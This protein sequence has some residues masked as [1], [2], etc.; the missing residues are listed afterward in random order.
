MHIAIEGSVAGLAPG[1]ETRLFARG[2]GHDPG[3]E[4]AVAAI[5]ADV[6]AR[7]DDALRE[8][9]RRVDGV[10]LDALEVPRAT[11][12]AALASL[13][14]S[15]RAALEQAT[16]AISTF[17]RA[18][19]PSP[20]EMEVRPG[21]RLG[22]RAEPLRRVGVYAPGGRAAYPS[23][24]L[25]GVVPARIAGVDE[26]IVCSPPGPDGF[27]RPSV[28]AAC[29]L[30][31]AD[32][33]F[34]LGGAGAIAALAFGTGS[35]PRAD[36][37]FGPGNAY[38]NEA[39]RQLTGAVAIDTPAGPS[40]VL[41]IA[42]DAANPELAAA[43][44][45]AQSEHD[46]D[47]AAVLVAT[48]GATV[49]AVRTSLRRLMAEQ[50]RHDIIA[51]ALAANGGLL[52]AADLDEALDFAARYAPEH[53][54]LLVREP[55]RALARVRSAGTVLLGP[56]S[57]VPFGDYLTGANHVLPTGGLAR[58][59]SGLSTLDFLRWFTYQEIDDDAATAL[60]G[61][62]RTLAVAEGLPAHAAAAE[63]RCEATRMAQAEGMAQAVG[64]AATT[65]PVRGPGVP[66][67]TNL[68]RQVWGHEPAN[69]TPAS[70]DEE[71]TAA[72]GRP[73][74]PA[75]KSRSGVER[76]AQAGRDAAP[77]A[78][79]EAE[80]RAR[81]A[82]P[83]R[84]AYRALDLYNPRR[85]PV[86]VDLS[87]NTSLFGPSPAAVRALSKFGTDA[88]TRYPSTYADHLKT[89]LADTL[90]VE[91]DNIATG[92][93]SDDVIDSAVRAFCDPG[94]VIAY[95]EPTFEMVPTLAGMNAAR[96]AA[97]S[98]GAGFA[99]DADALLAVRARVTYV[100]RPN[101]P[102][103][104]LFERAAVERVAAGAAGVVLVDEAYAD[105]AG[106]TLLDL[107]LDGHPV[108]IVRT[109]SKAYGL[110]GLRVGFAV[111]P[112][113]LIREIE[114]ARGP[115]KVNTTA[116]AAAAAAL[117]EDT[118]WVQVNVASVRQN[119]T[120]LAGALEG[121]GLQTW[122]S[123]A[124]FL[125]VQAPEQRVGAARDFAAA[126]RAHG[127]AVRPFPQLP[128]AG[129]CI[130]VS[131]GPWSMMERLLEAVGEE[132]STATRTHSPIRPGPSP[133]P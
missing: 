32:R 87:D 97:V 68:D 112:A 95:P 53:L 94:D 16:D 20:L 75:A 30:A 15:V 28:L 38:V 100:C 82:V 80:R 92:C 60:A 83:L 65:G 88:V 132:V 51:A 2:R 102:T 26:V 14:A 84:S 59:H 108:V 121:V 99:L 12:D 89:A 41:V 106:E 73:S 74:R 79:A 58:A 43:E 130:R 37:I 78:P 22:R 48:N 13:D 93:G 29:T 40:E 56:S 55:R 52:E 10:E 70:S 57:S 62:T 23:S 125:L 77:S 3:V 81:I 7:G 133:P 110:A 46:P 1:D 113:A 66:R 98:L 42:D 54:V 119:R 115:Y 91:P 117:R 129:E 63:L 118:A 31:R 127:I 123:A 114:K 128:Q 76:S 25:M 11:L 35:V 64:R 69:H 6:R 19:L 61:P 36:K 39:K 85:T 67:R 17:H 45:I 49:R 9:A 4:R 116:E 126:L 8:L 27:P 103:G 71:T 50:P 33:V 101:N 107:A 86:A 124:N 21:V 90:G 120:R 72:A 104:T 105:F 24:V 111:G 18:Q 34:A 96:P 47:A 44:L 122:P 5:V 109:L 131:V